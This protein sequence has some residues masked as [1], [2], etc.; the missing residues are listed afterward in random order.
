MN[1]ECSDCGEE[2]DEGF[3]GDCPF[4]ES[5]NI[6]EVY[7]YQCDDCNFIWNGDSE[8]GEECPECN[9]ENVIEI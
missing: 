4:C 2:F 3:L 1:Y 8:D 6:F 5:H 9:S 7:D